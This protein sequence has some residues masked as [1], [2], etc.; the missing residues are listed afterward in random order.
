M[1]SNIRPLHPRMASGRL[2]PCE[3]DSTDSSSVIGIMHPIYKIVW[4][5]GPSL[6]SPP[7]SWVPMPLT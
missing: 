1:S 5:P 6:A 4:K 3:Q 7:S 2:R